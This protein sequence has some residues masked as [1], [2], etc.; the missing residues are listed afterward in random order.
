VNAIICIRRKA[1]RIKI[2]F[3]FQTVFFLFI[4]HSMGDGSKTKRFPQDC[5]PF[6]FLAMFGLACLFFCAVGMSQTIGAI[7]S[8]PAQ[9]GPYPGSSGQAG[10][11]VVSQS[12]FSGSIPEGKAT[13]A[14]LPLSFKEALDRGLRNNLGILLQSD[15]TLAARGE[16][17]KE[18]S[19]LLPNVSAQVSESAT[20][21]DLA[22][23]GFRLGL[24]GVPKVVG[25]IGIFQSGVFLSQSLFNYNLLERTRSASDSEKAAHFSLKNARE[26]VV[27]AVGNGYLQALAGSARVATA[28]AQVETAQA[29]YDKAADQ[30]KAGVAPAISTLR[31]RVEL[32]TRQ[33]QLIASRNDYAKEKLALG[34]VI[35]LPP[36]Q[37]FSLTTEA[38]YE[39]LATASL[40]EDLQ[41]AYLMRAD[42]MAA[43]QQVR[44]AEEMRRAATAE[45]YPNLSIA[46]NY[47]DAGIR[48]GSS[49]GVFQVGASLNIPIFTGGK[50]HADVLESEASLRQSRQQ[51]EDLRGQID[52]DVRAARLDLDSAAE[53]VEVARSTVDLANQTLI[54]ARDRFAAG[55]TD[56]LEVVQA[57]EAL[58]QANESLISSLYAH[59]LSK[60][61]LARA[62]GFAEEGVKQYLQ[63]K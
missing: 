11:G 61:E 34:R 24:P 52:Y 8:S 5:Q 46:E 42:Y 13:S 25:P 49:H 22:A 48:P 45:Y 28:Q 1:G 38:P 19:A 50:T 56:N 29:L 55:V 58:A 44:A 63:S 31:A 37:E 43:A 14:V 51:L 10:S 33:Q 21:I 57:Q 2:F 23:Q 27:L 16:K 15:T 53:Q 20:E 17:W 26:L 39:P 18:L 3:G 59:N 32:Q 47:G 41:R 4:F 7:S 30:Q 54:Q 40:D 35:G 12:P 6:Q 36:G 60:I 9:A 62:V